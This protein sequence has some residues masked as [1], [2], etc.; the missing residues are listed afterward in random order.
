MRR[1]SVRRSRTTRPEAVKDNYEDHK[2]DCGGDD[3]ETEDPLHQ[4]AR[5]PKMGSTRQ[6]VWRK[7]N[8]LAIKVI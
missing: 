5:R 3:S 2:S 7:T 8:D 1:C 6:Q 4:T